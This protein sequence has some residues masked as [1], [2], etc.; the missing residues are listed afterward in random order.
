MKKYYLTRCQLLLGTYVEIQLQTDHDEG[1][2]ITWSNALFSEIRR[3]HDLLG[4]HNPQSELSLLNTALLSKVNKPHLIG[5]DMSKILNFAAKLYVKSNT[6][7]DISVAAALVKT[8]FLPN[9]FNIEQHTVLGDF[10]ALHLDGNVVM[11]LKPVCIDLGGIAKGYAV[12]CAIELLPNH[13]TAVINAGGDMRVTDWE[14]KPVFIRYAARLGGQKKV[15]MQNQALASS[16]SY[17]K[18]NGSQFINPKTGQNI[19]VKGA[20]SVFAKKAMYADAL[21]KALQFLNNKDAKSLLHTYQATAIKV[22]RF[23]LSSSMV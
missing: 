17:Y 20:V 15:M 4:F 21:T 14:N 18:E 16:A 8:H 9:H 3:I 7:Y 23:G 2:L 10:S 6:Y 13:I 22:N 1:E 5:N 19:Q 12:D 11:S